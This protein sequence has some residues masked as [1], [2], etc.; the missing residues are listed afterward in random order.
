MDLIDFLL[1]L[2]GLLLWLNWLSVRFDP[3]ARPTAAT[4]AG[5]LRKAGYPRGRRWRLA[6]AL[7]GLLLGRTLLYWHI[8]TAVNWFPSLRLVAITLSFPC[9]FYSF[10]RV[11]L[12]SGLSFVVMLVAFYSGLLLLSFLR[13]RTPE[14]DPF[15]RL[16]R[17][18]LGWVARWPWP[19][20]LI[21][22]LLVA[23]GLWLALQPLLTTLAIL[24]RPV[25]GPHRLEQ[26]LLIGLGA[27]LAWKYFIAGLLTLHIVNSYVFLGNHAFWNFVTVAAHGLL[28]PLQR[29]P[30]R[31]GRVDFAPVLGLAL[32]FVLAEFGSR[33]LTQLYA[34]LPW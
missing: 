7:G 9:D 27:Y 12:F 14:G 22:P 29:L 8:G 3:L 28:R 33:G 17:A 20:R 19:L 15:L 24:P 6:L 30:L 23:G 32:V 26:A 25:S 16:A 1:N 18:H 13:E 10:D 4:L 11:L 34:R 2:A 5:T 31:M 21:L